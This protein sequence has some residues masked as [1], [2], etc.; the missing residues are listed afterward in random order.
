MRIVYIDID[1][2]RPDHLGC[3]G[4][5]R[6]TSRTIDAIARD[7]V[8]FQNAYACDAP[9]LPS[10]TALYSG[11]FGIQTGVVGHGGT[12]AQP[13]I[14]GPSRSFQDVFDSQGFARQLQEL[15]YHTAMVSPFGQ[16]H[17]A[18]HF[19]AGFNE[20]HN[21][22]RRGMESAEE[23]QPIIEKWLG[24]NIER[25]NWFLHV[26]YWDPH[27]PYRV[28]LDIENSFA[29]DPIPEWLDNDEIIRR[30]NE[31][32]GPHTSLDIGMY[33]GSGNPEYPR[34]PGQVID[35]ASMR[36]MIDGYDMG[37]RYVDD[38]MAKIV[39]LLKKAGVYE[40]TAII[41]SADHGENLGE[42]GN[43]GEH[44]TADDATC[45]IP[46]IIKW[47]GGSA[48]IRNTK[49][50]YNLDLPPTL[51]E[52]L[53]GTHQPLWDGESFAPALLSRENVGRDEVILSQ[54]AHVCQRSVRWADW[55]YMR[56]YHDGFHLFPQ[57]MLFN[58]AD[59]PH[60][61]TNLAPTHPEL[62]QEGQWRLSRWHDAQ[63]QK[64]A[65]TGTNVEDPLWTVMKEGGP[66]HARLGDG[67]LPGNPTGGIK[68]FH[69]YLT[70]LEVTGRKQGADQLREKYAA[71]ITRFS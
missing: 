68:G 40:E 19:Y 54:C 43:Y 66:F 14:E 61:Q 70:R 44:G 71:L 13:K 12:A 38:Q 11:R 39:A 69:Q 4:Y 50:Q 32:A 15:G 34:H 7:G 48:G 25:E 53:G 59:D 23:V 62:C 17:A 29:D 41:I 26:N 8:L 9:C 56:T 6:N 51:M 31:M 35:R 52:L 33:H 47:P 55:L 28:P 10:R 21:T 3:Y 5:S 57:E 58:L 60:E 27:T 24:E 65:L 22:G 36:K 49:F 18:W 2:L 45:R 67:K 63:M 30:H 20:I 1:S 16:R 42:L 64:M 46:L 37:V